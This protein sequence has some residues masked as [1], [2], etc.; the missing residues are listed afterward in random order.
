MLDLGRAKQDLESHLTR[1]DGELGELEK[2]RAAARQEKDEYAGYG[3]GVGEAASETSETERDMALIETLEQTREHVK[4]ALGRLEDGSYGSCRTCGNQI[5]AERL[6]AWPTAD[7][8]VD[9]KS[10]DNNHQ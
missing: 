9:C 4:A 1:L 7:Q 3:N 10:K 5:P 6:E 8:C 2:A